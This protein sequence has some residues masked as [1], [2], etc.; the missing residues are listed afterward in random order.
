MPYGITTLSNRTQ[1][2]AVTFLF[3]FSAATGVG[4]STAAWGCRVRFGCMR[5]SCMGRGG[6]PGWRVRCAG[7]RT[8]GT[9][10]AVAANSS[11]AAG[12]SSSGILTASGRSSAVM[13]ARRRRAATTAI[14][15]AACLNKAVTAPAVSIAPTGPGAH[16]E[17]DAVV[18]IAW[19][20]EAHGRAGVGCIVVIAVRTD[21]LNTDADDDLG[22]NSLRHGHESQQDRSTEDGFESAHGLTPLRCLRL[23]EVREMLLGRN[24]PLGNRSHHKDAESERRTL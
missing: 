10:Y 6:S 13:P 7:S 2:V 9:G 20:I 19:T 3:V 24:E 12:C 22:L 21:R 5:S 23:P 1:R 8:G 14:T 16:A 4:C 18:E 15:A 17:E 11:T